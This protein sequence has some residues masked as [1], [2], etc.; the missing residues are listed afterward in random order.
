MVIL[1]HIRP[2]IELEVT[3]KLVTPQGKYFHFLHALLP[4]ESF[5]KGGAYSITG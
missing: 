1:H 3:K 2:L 5:K 4:L